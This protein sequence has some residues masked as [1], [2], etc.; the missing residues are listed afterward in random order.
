MCLIPVNSDAPM[1]HYPVTTL[2]LIAATI[3]SFAATTLGVGPPAEALILE[4]GRG[5]QPTQWLTYSFVHSGPTHLIANLIFLW[6]FGMVI[7][8]KLGWWKFLLLYAA[9]GV[10]GGAILQ[11]W[12]Q[13]S[14]GPPFGGA[15]ASLAIF[16]LMGICLIW[17]PL[18]NLQCVMVWWYRVIDV[19]IPIVWFSGL[20][21]AK[22]IFISTTDQFQMSG[23][24][25]HSV[26]ATIGLCIGV[27]MLK[28][29]LV[30]CEGWDVFSVSKGSHIVSY[31]EKYRRPAQDADN[32]PDAT[33]DQQ[34][35]SPHELQ[36]ALAK[37]DWFSAWQA[38]RRSN[39]SQ[40]TLVSPK[41]LCEIAEGLYRRRTYDLAAEA[42]HEVLEQPDEP[43]PEIRLKYAAVLTEIQKRPKAALRVL[44]PLRS[45]TLPGRLSNKRKQITRTATRMIDEGCME[46]ADHV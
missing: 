2:G 32:E 28:N 45:R 36:E 44:R 20:Y 39:E 14:V 1:Y 17:S 30:D 3:A 18:N 19:E 12:M 31:F 29:K 46:I 11:W 40:R 13:N 41:Q 24:F 9:I 38:Y 8:G 33:L 7:E 4:F 37:R 34:Q 35:N 10:S 25:G 21:I 26:G 43:P 27:S 5:Y 6:S 22:E 15:G 16:G 42:F 23:A